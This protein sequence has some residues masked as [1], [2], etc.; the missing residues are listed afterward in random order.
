MASCKLALQRC[1]SRAKKDS[2]MRDFVKIPRFDIIYVPFSIDRRGSGD[3]RAHACVTCPA[4][5]VTVATLPCGHG[6]L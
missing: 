6:S 3:E 4:V 5:I 2:F 1:V